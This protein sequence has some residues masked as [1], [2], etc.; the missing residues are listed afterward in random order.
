MRNDIA[1]GIFKTKQ[2][3]IKHDTL[4]SETLRVLYKIAHCIDYSNVFWIRKSR[5]SKKK[6]VTC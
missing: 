1:E 6:D 5:V 4:G 3:K 2:N